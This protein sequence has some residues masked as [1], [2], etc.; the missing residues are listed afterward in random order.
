[1]YVSPHTLS[2]YR[3][4]DIYF[5]FDL[6]HCSTCCQALYSVAGGREEIQEEDTDYP[7]NFTGANMN[8]FSSLM[9]QTLRAMLA[10]IRSTIN[11]GRKNPLSIFSTVIHLDHSQVPK[12]CPSTAGLRLLWYLPKTENQKQVHIAKPAHSS[13]MAAF[14]RQ[15][16]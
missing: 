6:K 7:V 15:R 13:T 12:V 2:S 5:V 3:C 16:T 1:M 9:L 14:P 4:A 8:L 10:Q 11:T